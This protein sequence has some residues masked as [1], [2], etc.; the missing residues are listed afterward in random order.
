MDTRRKARKRSG[1]KQHGTSRA[2]NRKRLW[3]QPGR[4][5]LACAVSECWRRD[6]RRDGT[7]AAGATGRRRPAT[8]A[9][10]QSATGRPASKEVR[11]LS[12]AL[13]SGGGVPRPLRRACVVQAGGQEGRLSR[14]ASKRPAAFIPGISRTRGSGRWNSTIAVKTAHSAAQKPGSAP[15]ST[16]GSKTLFTQLSNISGSTLINPHDLNPRMTWTRK[17][18]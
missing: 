2:V 15:Y 18:K 3:T 8:R 6:S 1:E 13:Y 9:G 10:D 14:A 17:G 7:F 11:Y 16:T 4:T 12:A 5:T